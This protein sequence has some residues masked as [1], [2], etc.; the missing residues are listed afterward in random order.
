MTRVEPIIIRFARENPAGVTTARRDPI[1]KT[2]EAIVPLSYFRAKGCPKPRII[3][4]R[5]PARPGSYRLHAVNIDF[6]PK[7]RDGK[8]W[9]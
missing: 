7:A 5:L 2:N 1:S 9:L 3:T 8:A 4:Q 6:E